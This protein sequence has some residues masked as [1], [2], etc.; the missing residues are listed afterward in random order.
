MEFNPS[1]KNSITPPQ[2]YLLYN[3]NKNSKTVK[4]YKQNKNVP[5]MYRQLFLFWVE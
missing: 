4:K 2:K 1:H 5:N 3:K